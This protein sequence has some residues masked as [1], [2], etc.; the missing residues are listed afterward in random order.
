MVGLSK[1]PLA[2]KRTALPDVKNFV[3]GFLESDRQLGS[4]SDPADPKSAQ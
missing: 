3:S 2:K 4:I 1:N